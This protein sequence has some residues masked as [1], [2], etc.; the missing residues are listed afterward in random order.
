MCEYDNQ[1][2]LPITSN[3]VFYERTKYIEIDCH[4]VREKIF[5]VVLLQNLLSQSINLQIFSLS[6]P[7]VLWNKFVTWTCMH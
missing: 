5:S 7:L 1:V 4:F 3:L 2:V 6:L